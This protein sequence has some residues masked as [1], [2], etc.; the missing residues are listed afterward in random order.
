MKLQQICIQTESCIFAVYCVYL[1][2][3]YFV[4]YSELSAHSAR[5][6]QGV[7]GVHSDCEVKQPWGDS[8]IYMIGAERASSMRYACEVA[9][10][11][12]KAQGARAACCTSS[13]R[14]CSE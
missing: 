3:N 14:R 8:F 12:L 4:I 13:V 7:R 2:W 1:W 10:S 9:R 6:A 11:A 5:Q